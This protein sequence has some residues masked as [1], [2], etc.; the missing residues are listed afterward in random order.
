MGFWSGSLVLSSSALRT[1]KNQYSILSLKI[2]ASSSKVVYGLSLAILTMLD[3]SPY[4]LVFQ[5][6][7]FRTSMACSTYL[8]FLQSLCTCYWLNYRECLCLKSKLWKDG[9]KIHLIWNIKELL[10]FCSP[11]CLQDKKHKSKTDYD[12]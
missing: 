10:P 8:W 4:G 6:L 3:R 9:A 1:I 2:K 12:L 5:S 11:S 7:L